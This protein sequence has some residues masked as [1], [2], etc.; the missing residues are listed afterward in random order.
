MLFFF[1]NAESGCRVF[2]S[3]WRDAPQTRNWLATAARQRFAAASLTIVDD[4]SNL[5]N[6]LARELIAI[7]PIQL[8]APVFLGKFSTSRKRIAAREIFLV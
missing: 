6:F 2:S 4:S 1:T 7:K 5:L 8:V 3:N